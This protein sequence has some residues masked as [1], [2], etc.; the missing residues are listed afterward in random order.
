MNCM[1][2]PICTKTAVRHRIENTSFYVY[3][4]TYKYMYV[5]KKENL[6]F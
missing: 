3:V 2:W 4:R 5:C 6:I 1:R